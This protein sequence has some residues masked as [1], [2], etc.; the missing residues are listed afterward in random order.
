[1]AAEASHVLSG[2]SA[3]EPIHVFGTDQAGRHDLPG[4]AF[5]VRVHG[6]QV[7]LA[8]GP[9]GNA[10]AVPFRDTDCRLL[11]LK[12]ISAYVKEFIQYVA[13]HP[14]DTFQVM[15]FAC[16]ANAYD[17][18]KLAV[19]FA[20]APNNCLLPG[21]WQRCLDRKLSAR[22][23]LFDPT[24]RLKEPAW[25]ERVKRYLELNQPLWNV[26][27]VELVSFGAARS[28]VANDVLAR[29]LGLK[30]RIMGANDSYYG[31]DSVLAAEA[32]AVWY[33]THFLSLCDFDQTAQPSQIR[34]TGTAVSGGL[35]MD[36][37]DVNADD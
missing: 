28:V 5:A 24:T 27:A 10:Y 31:R 11:P 36:Q 3:A 34:I 20:T 32:K 25:R 21:V 30:H 16:G 6:A 4:A 8:N 13:A 19:L 15:R 37:I 26:P 22:V 18:A 2:V 14:Q 12:L 35:H 9:A 7:G 1:M 33:S 23:L 17:D 29:G